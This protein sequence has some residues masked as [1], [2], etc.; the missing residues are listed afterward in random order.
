MLARRI[1]RDMTE[2]GRSVDGILEQSVIDP[3]RRLSLLAQSITQIPAL[4]EAFVRQF[5]TTH[6]SIRQY[7]AVVSGF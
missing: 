1:K 7:R 5:R 6:F 3:T 2:R 4:R